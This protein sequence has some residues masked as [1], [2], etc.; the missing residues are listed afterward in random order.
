MT[1]PVSPPVS[2]H[3][4]NPAVFYVSSTIVITI[5]LFAVIAPQTADATFKAI[6]AS[7][8]NNASWYYILSVAI[9]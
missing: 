9:I 4:I 2:K 3:N 5:S 6:Q 1:Q 7:I 8:V